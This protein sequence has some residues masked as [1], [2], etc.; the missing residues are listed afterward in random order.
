MRKRFTIEE[1]AIYYGV[2]RNTMGKWIKDGGVDLSDVTSV[3]DFII[4]Q[5]DRDN[6]QSK[7]LIAEMGVN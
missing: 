6:A 1:L 7:V 4:V 3:L 5:N 2:H